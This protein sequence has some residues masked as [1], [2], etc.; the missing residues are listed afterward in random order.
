VEARQSVVITLKDNIDISRGDILVKTSREPE[1][2][3]ELEADICWMD[4]QSLTN[5]KTY[6]LHHGTS[7]TKAKIVSIDYLQIPS[8][9]EKLPANALQMNDIARIKI[10]TA[11][12]LAIDRYSENP[13][14]GSFI[15]ID[16]YSNNTVAVG[17]AC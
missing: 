4:S 3:K 10:K 17:F 14:D 6:L 9:L 15:L 13:S 12:P 8:T 16:E 2:M 1:L 5:G 11:K 7:Q